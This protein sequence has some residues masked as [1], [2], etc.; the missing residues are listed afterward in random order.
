ML[1]YKIEIQITL[2]A[3]IIGAAVLT[4]G[5]FA[6]K[7]LSEIVFSINQQTR[8][9]NRLFLMKDIAND[10][11]AVENN[12]SLYS[13]TKNKSDLRLYNTL[14]NR[15]I[16]NIEN[17]SNTTVLNEEDQTL[18]DSIAKLSVEK[19]ELWQDILNLHHSVKTTAPSFSE[20]YSKLEE[21]K[22]DT[23]IGEVEVETDT[24]K[25]GFL[26]KIFGSKKPTT[27]TVLDTTFVERT[28]EKDSIKQEIQNLETEMAEEDRKLN[29][30]ESRLIA[31]NIIITKKINELILKAE[32]RE[33]EALTLKT[34]EADELAELTYKRLAIFT[35]TA[36]V[37][38]L[39]ALFVFFN[40]LRK[41]RSYQR[42]LQKAKT[43]AENLARAKEQ[44]ASNVSHEM[45]T[46]VNAIYGL[47]EQLLHQQTESY[48]N[49][50]ISIIAQSAGHLKNIIN[51][52]LDFSKIQSNKLKIDSVHFSPNKVFT[53]VIQLQGNEAS[54]KGISLN[55]EVEGELP[56]ALIGDPMR[57]KQILINLIGNSIK[58]TDSGNVTLHVKPV[59]KKYMTYHLEMT[60]SDTGIGIPKENLSN[61][62]DEFVQLEN[63]SGKK[64]S[65]TGLGL[66]IV[67]KL[68]ELQK[69]YIEVKSE[70]NLGTEVKITIPFAEGK[71]E[72]IKEPKF[73]TVVIPEKYRSLK[74][75]VADDEEFNLFLIKAI[76]K[77]WNMH[78]RETTN[79]NEVVEA[80][81]N[82]DFDLILMDLRMPGK[83]GIE[84]TKEILSFKP[85]TKIIAVTATN[86][87]IDKEKCLNAGMKG[88][89]LK[90]FSEK[91]LVE[92][93]NSIMKFETADKPVNREPKIDLG[94][95][96][97]LAN[98]DEIFLREMS[99]LFL[100]STNN[101]LDDIKKAMREK[102]KEN[103]A[104]A[105]HKMA[106][107]CKHFH[108]TDLYNIIKHLEM[109][110][111]NNSD[112]N[113]IS[114]EIG[115]LESE[116][117]E[118][119]NYFNQTFNFS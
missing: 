92:A 54:K 55:F 26:K 28:I 75:L 74:V 94:E 116:I 95:A 73:D 87:Q 59:K 100:K 85:N 39:I 80:A 108:A 61:I 33:N 98:G 12:V 17:L 78:Y 66:S 102:N 5:Y 51:D 9:D 89:L 111:Q 84:A 115:L 107:P 29:V 44:F 71:S 101:G 77:K 64:Y 68:V 18:T 114:S 50:Q 31:E 16:L 82:E 88:F 32:K 11:V 6:Y 91:E 38:L 56:S 47:A 27:T 22:T 30:R 67:K 99:Q 10:L 118:V 2:I 49:E 42:A 20:I 79:G 63:Q 25:K 8:P 60:V 19:L 48:I 90:P 117:N 106:A 81:L 21:Q 41:S 109:E 93:I 112:W 3:L 14:Q 105:C 83:S 52:T 110:A 119:N 76:F 97:R 7:S 24:V 86:E 4:T 46:P 43:E 45:R 69:G 70:E 15:I 58:F 96:K 40:Y 72:N 65:G 104:E 103:I 37:L 35:I 62:F 113:L 34:K 53:E 57:L 1:K 23:I 36:V 13:L